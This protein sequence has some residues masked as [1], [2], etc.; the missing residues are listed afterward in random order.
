MDTAEAERLRRALSLR[1]NAVNYGR[2]M[3]AASIFASFT[4][5]AV[6][7][8]NVQ[9]GYLF[10]MSAAALISLGFFI[11]RIPLSLKSGNI[12]ELNRFIG[13]LV[14]IS[15]KYSYLAGE[16]LDA[17]GEKVISIVELGKE[18]TITLIPLDEVSSFYY[19]H[20]AKK[21]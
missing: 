2:F 9:L 15:T 17:K 14:I 3:I 5:V 1:T 18:D 4:G 20:M 8:N 21:Q 6:V 16:L 13:K 19:V 12:C 11:S 7:P 10:F